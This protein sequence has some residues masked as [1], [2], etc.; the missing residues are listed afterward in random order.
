MGL[1]AVIFFIGF[2]ISVCI[3]IYAE[4]KNMQDPLGYKYYVDWRFVAYMARIG[5]WCTAI[6]CLGLLVLNMLLK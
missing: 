1:L 6:P 4:F 3:M 2:I 5:V